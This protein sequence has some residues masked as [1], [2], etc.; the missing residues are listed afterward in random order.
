VSKLGA[1]L[2]VG[3]V[4]AGIAVPGARPAIAVAEHFIKHDQ[5][6]SDTVEDALSAAVAVIN[7]TKD[8]DIADE[9]KFRAAVA[10]YDAA[11]KMLHSALRHAP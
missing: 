6:A 10:M 7:S 3:K 8:V 5:P 1:I 4:V 11:T 2:E 9:G